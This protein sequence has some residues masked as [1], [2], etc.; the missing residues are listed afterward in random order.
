MQK[1]TEMGIKLGRSNGDDR[2]SAR[3]VSMVEVLPAPHSQAL[4]RT[5]RE[6]EFRT[7]YGFTAVALYRDGRSHRTDLGDFA[8]RLGDSLLVIGP[9]SRLKRLQCSPDFLV[10]EP[11]PSDQ[12]VQLVQA[13]LTMGL[14]VAGVVASICGLP[15]HFSMLAAAILVLLSGALSMEEAYRGVEWQAIFLVA[16][17]YPLSLAMVQTG[18]AA[19]IAQAVV[20][21]VSPLGPLGLAAAGYLLTAALTQVMGGQV[22]ALVT[23]PI[24]ISAAV[25]QQ[26]NPQAVAVATAIACSASFFTPIAHPVNILMIGPANYT[27]GDFFRI[28][29]RL[30]IVCFL[31]LLAGL[32]LFWKL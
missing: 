21:A 13:T 3:G 26:T 29:W 12:P 19:Q 7:R 30:T 32:A 31:T 2:I 9:R 28:G 5:L 10:L 25:S 18:L 8:L 15:V 24:M 16:G 1:L 14:I 4:G 27:F 17:M 23:G 11:D 22:T 6:L 20:P